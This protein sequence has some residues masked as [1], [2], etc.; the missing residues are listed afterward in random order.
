MIFVPAESRYASA[1]E[2][3]AIDPHDL[4]A[5]QEHDPNHDA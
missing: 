4:N 1:V 3:A 5:A 2:M